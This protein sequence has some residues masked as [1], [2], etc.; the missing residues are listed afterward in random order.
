MISL[1]RR[2][3]FAL[4]LLA[5]L[6]WFAAPA[7]QAQA[8]PSA[9]LGFE[10]LPLRD[11]IMSVNGKGSRALAVFSDPNCPYCKRLERELA[12]LPDVRLY[13]FLIPVLVPDSELKSR[14]IWCAAQPQASW[15]R[16]MLDGVEPAEA[17]C[18][19]QPVL[20]RNLTLARRLGVQG[21]PTL[22]TQHN[23]RLVGVLPAAQLA[24]RL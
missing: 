19:A 9:A 4:P 22:L 14:R 3:A 24:A 12:Q 5:T 18:E 10:Q 8:V 21:T 16:W 20:Q 6:A 11:A 15:R 17:A 7:A 1:K 13:T 2:A 23:E